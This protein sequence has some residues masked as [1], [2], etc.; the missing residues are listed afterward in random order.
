MVSNNKCDYYSLSL[1]PL[2]GF[3]SLSIYWMALA[4][5]EARNPALS[6][7]WYWILNL[8]PSFLAAK[9][10]RAKLIIAKGFLFS[11]NSGSFDPKIHA[12][13]VQDKKA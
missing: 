8:A 7:H 5:C 13:G 9:A 1:T 11:Q 12:Q 3:P 2:L 4:S 10:Q 6:N